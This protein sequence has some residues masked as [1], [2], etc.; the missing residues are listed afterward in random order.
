MPVCSRAAWGRLYWLAGSAVAAAGLFAAYLSQSRTQPTNSDGASNALQAWDMLHG[1][2][3]LRGWHV[4]DVSFYTTE[5]PQYMMLEAIRGLGPDVVH[6]GAAMSYTLLVLLA[7]W[8][9][10]GRA[11]GAE[12]VVRALLAAGIMLAPQLGNA[13]FTL[14]GSP[15]HIGTGVPLLVTWLVIDRGAEAGRLRWLVPVVAGV[16]LAWTAVGDLLAE[17]VGAVPLAAVCGMRA[18]QGLVHH[19]EPLRARWCELSLGAAA[20]LSVVAASAATKLIASHGGWR[21]MPVPTGVVANGTMLRSN[22]ALTFRGILELFGAYVSGQQPGPAVL[23]AG[24]H[25]IGVVLVA[26]GFW[27]ALRRFFRAELLVQVLTVAIAVNLAAYVFG[28][29]V[30]D[31]RSTR[32]IVVVLPCGAVLAG[33]L[34]AGRLTAGRLL[35]ARPAR[36]TAG[37][38]GGAVLA[39]YCAMLGFNASQPAVPAENSDV[40]AWLAAHGLTR[41]LAG[42]WQ[43]NSMTLDSGNAIQ[44]RA[45]SGTPKQPSND[46]RWE[47]KPAWYDPVSHY[48]SFLVTVRSPNFEI[49]P[50]LSWGLTAKAGRPARVYQFGR[51]TIAVWNKNLLPFLR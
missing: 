2:V 15:D 42:Y 44:V 3:L 24:V 19:R 50:V 23:F 51:Y 40:T 17:L 35:Q 29:Q 20:I 7:A 38:L 45:M 18:Y 36:A 41:G 16:L 4:S 26:C 22:S 27:L 11:K 1:N 49:D 32:E 13:T 28:V 33:R 43:A 47:A 9:A 5:L 30:Q 48:A 6:V 31:I 34:L 25:V 12:G 10:K 8:L 21:A 46:D 14:L 39:S 37:V